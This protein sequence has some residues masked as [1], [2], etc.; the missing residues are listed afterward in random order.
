MPDRFPLP[1][2]R[3]DPGSDYVTFGVMERVLRR[4]AY[5]YLI[6]VVAGLV[7]YGLL[8]Y[9]IH[10]GQQDARRDTEQAAQIA[11]Q[12]AENAKRDRQIAFD[13]CVDSNRARQ[14]V[15]QIIILAAQPQPDDQPDDMDRRQRFIDESI[16]LLQ[17]SDCGAFLKLKGG[18]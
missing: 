10:Q 6:L 4:A 11:R 5:G 1:P 17:P 18:S 15:R 12:A 2:R 16:R 9:E 13:A 7:A 3:H 14:A 8:A